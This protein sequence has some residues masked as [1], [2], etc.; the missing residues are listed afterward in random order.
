MPDTRSREA[1]RSIETPAVVVDRGRLTRNIERVQQIGD[2]NR[3][4]V[5]PHIKTHKCIEVA[6]MQL[7]AGACGITASK[8]SEAQVFVEAGIPSVTVAFPVVESTKARRLVAAAA[9]RNCDLRFIMDSEVSLE[10]IER[11]VEPDG[12]CVGVYVKIDVGLGRVGLRPDAE[13]LEALAGRVASSPRLE[14][15]GLLSHAG[16]CYAASGREAVREIAESERR[17]L[18]AARERLRRAG[19]EVSDLSVGSTPTVLACSNFEGL[20]EIRPGNYVFFDLTAVRLGVASLGDVAFSV[21]AS[22]VSANE[23][24]A[25]IDAGSKVLSSD[26]GPHGT[27][28][29]RGYGRAFPIDA[30]ID[31]ATVDS[32]LLVEK[33]SE[34]H[35]FV[36]QGENRLRIGDRLRVV[37]NHSCPAANLADWFHVLDED[38]STARW[39]VAAAGKVV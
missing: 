11:A 26:L 4:A 37:P 19:L 9:P 24:Y 34:E 35:G 14:F 31:E 16:H 38:D 39:R 25:I 17:Q 33:L 32:S 10:A 23:T 1:L 21:L 12:R 20:G 5:R 6:Q 22:V 18:L 28:A 30:D 7:E 29:V 27:G 36:R 8:T 2:A 15:R 13:N 3:V